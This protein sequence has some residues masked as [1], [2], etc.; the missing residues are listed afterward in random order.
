MEKIETVPGG[1]QLRELE[2]RNRDGYARRRLS[3]F[4]FRIQTFEV[5]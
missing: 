3:L 4:F 2:E 5:D 1:E